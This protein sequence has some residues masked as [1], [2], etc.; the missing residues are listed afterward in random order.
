MSRQRQFIPQG[1]HAL[2]SAII[3]SIHRIREV[4]SIAVDVCDQAIEYSAVPVH[5][6]TAAALEFIRAG[7]PAAHENQNRHAK[8]NGSGGDAEWHAIGLEKL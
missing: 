4:N 6:H 1:T 5:I 2:R 8:D 7:P 3:R